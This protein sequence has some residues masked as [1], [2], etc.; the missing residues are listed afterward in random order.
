MGELS[1]GSCLNGRVS[2]HID[3]YLHC[4]NSRLDYTIIVFPRDVFY[5]ILIKIPKTVLLGIW[6]EIS[7]LLIFPFTLIVSACL[8][9]LGTFSRSRNKNGD[10]YS[11]K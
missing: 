4:G 9:V 7:F 11:Q 8:W 6:H 10:S 5:G 2:G 3:N 1:L